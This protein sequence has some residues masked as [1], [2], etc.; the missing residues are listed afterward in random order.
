MNRSRKKRLLIDA[1]S[2]VLRRG[3]S[4]IP[5]IGR[6]TLDLINAIAKIKDIPFEIVLFSQ[7]ING[8]RLDYY[9]F[10][11]RSVNFLLPA[12]KRVKK[13]TS[14]LLFRE[15][16]IGYDLLHIPHNY[17]EVFKPS[18]SVVTIHDAMC[19]SYPEDFLGHASARE[20]YRRLARACKGIATPSNSSKSDIVHYLGVKPETVTVI[21]WGVNTDVFFPQNGPDTSHYLQ[22][23]FKIENPYFF[24]VS[25]NVGRKNTISVMRSYK[26]LLERRSN[27]DLVLVWNSPPREYLNEFSSE[28]QNKRIH[29]LKSVTDEELR[30]LY[31]NATATWFPSKYE[32]FGLPVLESM[33]CGTPVVTSRNSSLTEVGGNAA[34]YVNPDD[35]DEMSN[36]MEQFEDG[37]Y[38]TET[39]KSKSLTHAKKFTWEKTAEAYVWFYSQNLN[40]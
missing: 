3:Q 40:I 2:I 32:G 11:F 16:F 30:I 22:G 34:L 15:I 12:S 4:Y 5:G 19:Y 35:L 28:I 8:R 37:K 29:I 6:T 10:P 18:N 31:S 17:S 33:S 9:S 21:P 14:T 38:C 23:K 26:R 27:H 7:T 36:I 13:L 20:K 1:N 24:S 25:C 39:L